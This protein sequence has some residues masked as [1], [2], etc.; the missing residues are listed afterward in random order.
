MKLEDKIA[1]LEAR[2]WALRDAFEIME[3]IHDTYPFGVDEWDGIRL[4]FTTIL[5][6]IVI[7]VRKYKEE[8][9]N[10]PPYVNQCGLGHDRPERSPLCVNG[11]CNR[12]GECVYGDE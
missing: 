9:N 8:L 10:P 11:E 1:A 12:H 4:K 6:G 5:A 2:K 7:K 3:G